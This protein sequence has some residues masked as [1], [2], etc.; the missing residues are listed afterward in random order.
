ML[1]QGHQDVT[2]PVLVA[3]PQS[4][5]ANW[6]T[7]IHASERAVTTVL[8]D[9]AHHAV[10]GS[11]YEQILGLLETAFPQ[12][13]I[14]AIGFTATPYR[15][16]TKNRFSVLPTCAFIREIPEMIQDG[17]LAPLTWLPLPLNIDLPTL[18]TALPAD[19]EPD[20]DQ[21]ALAQT[22]SRSTLMEGMIRQVIPHLAQRPTL[23]F[24]ASV[25]HAELLAA[26]LGQA[27]HSAIAVSGR[28]SRSQ[29][30]RIYAEWHGRL[31]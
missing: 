14:A 20:Y 6:S 23:V 1:M 2:A 16:D 15:G 18:S 10:E 8:I 25:A 22:L 12:E 26:L 29:R 30:E 28:T 27:G 24:A 4:L 3:T 13:S 21:R 5:L 19:G 31:R 7:F 11:L 9:E 17:W